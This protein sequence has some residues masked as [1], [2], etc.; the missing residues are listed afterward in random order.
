MS[1]VPCPKCGVKLAV[2]ALLD[3]FR[4]TKVIHKG[5]TSIV[6][7][8]IDRTLGRR[9]AIKVLRR[10][11]DR[12]KQALEVG[13]TLASLHHDNLVQT[14]HLGQKNKH[15]YIV[16]ELIT[17]KRLDELM[18]EDERISEVKV[19]RFVSDVAAGLNA[20][21]DAGI[22]HGNLTPR[23]ILFDSNGVAR[24]ID[25]QN[26]DS[27]DH[28]D[29]VAPEIAAN[30][31]ADHRADMYSLGTIAFEVMTNRLPFE[32]DTDEQKLQLRQ[33][34][35]SPDIRQFDANI[36]GSSAY[37]INRLLVTDP[38]QR[39]PTYEQLIEHAAS[40]IATC[41]AEPAELDPMAELSAAL[42][43]HKDELAPAAPSAPVVRGATESEAVEVL[44]S[45]LNDPTGGQP[46]R[47]RLDPDVELSPLASSATVTFGGLTASHT[48]L[49]HSVTKQPPKQDDRKLIA[50]VIIIV[51]IL[52]AIIGAVT[53]WIA[54][55]PVN[56]E[57]P[58]AIGVDDPIDNGATKDPFAPNEPV[59]T[60][61]PTPG[62]SETPDPVAPTPRNVRQRPGCTLDV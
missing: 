5:D 22:H 48:S 42:A 59:E 45:M 23:H 20:A 40:A 6:Y 58:E 17:G 26:R 12:A 7:E 1:A 27:T 32:A 29:Y 55:Q 38:E 41:E 19:M 60:V 46:I 28:V 14:Y 53:W 39:Y 52:F 3:Q 34:E 61:T 9:V 49:Q 31:D 11:D 43:D 21:A 25:F 36:N 15:H 57:Q 44:Q 13:R 33:D 8:A 35:I 37:V 24:V 51:V 56:P 18:G 10:N 4:L 30:N 62:I 16:M 54:T 47:S 50:I 2:P